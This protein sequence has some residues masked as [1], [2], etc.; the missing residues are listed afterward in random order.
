MKRPRARLA[1]ALALTALGAAWVSTRPSPT[2]A[3]ASEG[4]ASEPA[5]RDAVLVVSAKEH[6]LVVE[7]PVTGEREAFFRVGLSPKTVAVAADGRTAVVTNEGERVSG[8]SI[9]VVDLYATNLVRTIKLVLSAKP[10]DPRG[11]DREFHRPTGVAFVGDSSRVLVSCAIEG[12]LLLVDLVEARVVSAVEL[13]AADA[14]DVVVDHSGRFAYVANRG[15][16]TVSVVNISRMA[17]VNTIEA[18]GGPHGMALHPTRDEIWVTNMETNTISVIDLVEREERLEF[19]CG[20]MPVDVVFT[21]DGRYALVANMQEGNVSVIES[22]SLRIA[23]LVGL[24]RVSREQAKLRPVEFTGHFGRSPL[25]TQI[26]VDPDGDSA[27]VSTR[28]DDRIHRIDLSTWK[29]VASL[30]APVAPTCLAWS[31]VPEDAFAPLTGER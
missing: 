3:A 16:G 13:D 4:G 23:D 9:C 10:G 12:A 30:P 26:I 21:P 29:V 25:P 31:R 19:P 28:R 15:S 7:D 2:M 18:G 17:V 5:E 6:A 1:A 20:A 24:E 14:H 27:Y 8:T 22:E 11:L